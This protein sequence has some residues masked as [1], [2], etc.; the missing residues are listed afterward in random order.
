MLFRSPR[1]PG[2]VPPLKENA[3]STKPLP[4]RERLEAHRADASCAVC[5]RMMDPIGFSL[6][7]FDAVGVWRI[8]DTGFPIDPTGNM[9][10]G[11]KLDGPLSLRRALVGHSEAFIRTFTEKLLTYALGRGI[12]YYDMPAVRAIDREAAGRNNRFSALVLAI[13]KSVPFQMR[14][15]EE[16]QPPAA[17]LVAGR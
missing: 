2:A 3:D 10:D 15:A 9:V 17:G 4:V 16:S 1:P 7:N 14:R 5:H 12:E 6:E 8:H 11:T 13:V